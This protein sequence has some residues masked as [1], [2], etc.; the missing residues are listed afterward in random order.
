MTMLVLSS[1]H[2]VIEAISKS[3]VAWLTTFV[4]APC[5]DHVNPAADYLVTPRC[6]KVEKAAA[7]DSRGRQEVVIGAILNGAVY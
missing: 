5:L 1:L 3:T 7:H 2:Q 6:H 4:D